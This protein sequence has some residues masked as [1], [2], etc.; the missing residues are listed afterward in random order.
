MQV[1]RTQI[2]TE[3]EDDGLFSVTFWFDKST[4]PGFVT[5]ARDELEEP[6]VIYFE[7]EDQMHVFKTD[8]LAYLI[9]GNS[10][11]FDLFNDLSNAFFWT[12]LRTFS[13]DVA[14]EDLA[15]VTQCLERI[16]E[17]GRKLDM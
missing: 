10:I 1:D 8:K 5:I 7:A 16:F 17:L 3:S 14:S 4:V 13:L 15:D 2:D 6:D 9:S 11:T 12:T